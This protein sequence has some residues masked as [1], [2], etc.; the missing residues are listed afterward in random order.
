MGLAVTSPHNIMKYPKGVIA[1]PK[2]DEEVIEFTEDQLVSV[3]GTRE[4]KV[5]GN[6]MFAMNIGPFNG[7]GV[8]LSHWYNW[9]IVQ[10]TNGHQVLVPTKK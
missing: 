3:S 2:S 1:K 4:I 5:D 9:Q 10:D 8:F 7:K 6:P